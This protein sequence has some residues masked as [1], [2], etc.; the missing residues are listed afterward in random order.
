MRIWQH[1]IP[2]L[3][4]N[5]VDGAEAPDQV[6]VR[7]RSIH[8]LALTLVVSATGAS[9]TSSLFDEFLDRCFEPSISGEEP[10]SEDLKDLSIE[11]LGPEFVPLSEETGQRAF[12]LR[13]PDAFLI[14]F[15][16]SANGGPGCIV[17]SRSRGIELALEFTDWADVKVTSGE[18]GEARENRYGMPFQHHTV[19]AEP[20]EHRV[21]SFLHDGKTM[22]ILESC[23]E[24]VEC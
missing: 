12:H 11:D 2:G 21:S 24:T 10:N 6:R 22:L 20:P 16:G 8:P 13:E 14:V 23:G 19:F 15:D 17:L 9:A 3:T 18:L 1:A 7:W 5:P 4:R